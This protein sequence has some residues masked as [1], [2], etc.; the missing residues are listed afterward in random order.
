MRV[1]KVALVFSWLVIMFL[2]GGSF[3]GDLLVKE[4]S[5]DVFCIQYNGVNAGF[6]KFN[7]SI[8]VVDTFYPLDLSKKQKKL[9]RSEYKKGRIE[10]LINTNV[11][12][13]SIFG[14]QLFSDEAKVLTS[15]S[16]R[17]ELSKRGKAIFKDALGEDAKDLEEVEII[18][19][20]IAFEKGLKIFDGND[21]VE[22]F[23]V[24]DVYNRG[25]IIVN[26]RGKNVLFAGLLFFNRI[27]PD[28]KDAKLRDYQRELGNIMKMSPAKLIPRYGPV[29]TYDDFLFYKKY[30]DELVSQTQKYVKRGASIE[31]T[32][33]NVKLEEFKDWQYYAERHPVNIQRAY[34]QL[35]NENNQILEFLKAIQRQKKNK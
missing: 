4:I 6:F 23:D 2:P 34:E 21:A 15:L 7:N 5:K 9:V 8:Y 19:P 18:L 25:N 31:E 16:I 29:G 22:I 17:E 12:Y 35:K 33:D 24:Q 32:L 28:L 26:L 10:F 20:D 1:V 13:D 14:N 3:G 27:I 11:N 30:I